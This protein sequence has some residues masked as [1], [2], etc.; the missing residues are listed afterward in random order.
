MK[1]SKQWLNDFVDCQDLSDNQLYETLTTRVAEV[2]GIQLQAASIEQAR[3]ALIKQVKPFPGKDNLKIV[4]VN[5]GNE[6]LDVVCGATNCREKMLTVYLPPGAQLNTKQGK[7]VTIEKREFSGGIVSNGVLVSEFELGLTADHDSG[8]MELNDFDNLA[9]G[10]TLSEY[11]GKADTIIEIDNKSLTHRP[12]LWGH[13]GFAREISAILKRPLKLNFDQFSDASPEGERLLKELGRGKCKFQINI[14][15]LTKCRRFSCI[16]IDNVQISKSPLW[17]RRRLFSVGSNSKNLLVD[18]SN[19]VMFDVGQPNHTFD[20]DLLSGNKIFVRLA[21]EGEALL[22]LDGV[23]HKLT[24][25]DVVI[26][27][28]KQALGLAGVIGGQSSAISEKTKRV[29]LESAN[30]DP[31]VLRLST[32]RQQVRTDASNRFE[33][34]RS[35]YTPPFAIHRFIQLITKLDTN[36][37]ISSAVEDNFAIKP[38]KVVV[39]VRYSYIRQ[40]LGENISNEKISEIIQALGFKSS[41]K[42]ESDLQNYEV[43]FERATRDITIEDDF[44]EEVGRVYGYENI[45]EASPAIA[46]TALKVNQ[47]L[48]AENKLRDLLSA[49]GFSEFYNYSFMS[50]GVAS[51]LGYPLDEIIRMHNPIDSTCDCVRTTFV[52]GLLKV[53]ESNARFYDDVAMFEVGR[54]YQTKKTEFCSKDIPAKDSLSAYE[55]RLLGIVYKSSFGEK[56]ASNIMSP[57]LEKGAAFYS[58]VSLIKK[59][60][61]I[62]TKKEISIMPIEQNHNNNSSSNYKLLRNWMHPFRA[63]YIVINNIT[64]GQISEVGPNSGFDIPARSIIAEIDLHALVSTKEKQITFEHI[65]K[66]PNSYFEMSVVV[67]SKAYYK[68]LREFLI[69]KADNSLLKGLEVI[70]VYQGKPLKDDEKSIS[71]KFSF[72]ADDRTLSSDELSTIQNKL[73]EEVNK[74]KYSLRT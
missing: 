56:E 45:P 8:I 34:N 31:V 67:P 25:E 36:V 22:T 16:E 65:A 19:Y 50:E 1:I 48:E 57:S 35:P 7:Q 37:K 44:V 61:A 12:D 55:K 43:P 38:E 70:A 3:I 74:S 5:I 23:E 42:K 51:N 11:I 63:A 24:N 41:S 66:Y 18:L 58:V 27:D 4:T 69:S 17:I 53:L 59:I 33:K 49:N 72:G 52:P 46:S 21:K 13:F 71:V 30:F 9:P 39:P 64:I 68:E 47:I 20:A 32:K 26:A 73:I 6:N 54:A 60:S 62:F 28:E 29:L 10:K 2:D 40:R 14:D 15:P